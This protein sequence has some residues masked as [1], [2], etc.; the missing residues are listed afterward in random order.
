MSKNKVIIL[1]CGP[2]GGVPLIG[3]Q[4]GGFWGTCDP[5]N[6]KNR[7]MRASIYVEYEGKK[8]L[9]DTSPDLRQQFLT[10]GLRDI[11]AVL[12]THEHADHTHGIDE[13]RSLFFARKERTIPVYGS[14]ETLQKL[15]ESFSY[16]FKGGDHFIYPKI[17][18]SYVISN[19][20]LVQGTPISSFVQ[21]HGIGTS[22]GYRFGNVAYSTDV[23]DFDEHAQECLKGL[24]V[25]IIDC[26]S[27]ELK[28]SHLHLEAA[29]EWIEKMK[30]KRAI[31]THMN[32]SLDYEMLKKELPPYIEPAYDGM[33]IEF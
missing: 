22:L 20:F 14:E 9:V 1:G 13:L 21:I 10:F 25:W 24:D 23:T 11:D 19:T 15:K 12:Y 8:L 29:L 16:L 17:L 2:S 6:P 7:R 5:T 4:S 30:P 26:L 27:R 32:P 3:P 18:E 28:P 31:L 33:V